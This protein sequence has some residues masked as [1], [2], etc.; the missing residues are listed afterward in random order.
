MPSRSSWPSPS[1]EITHPEDVE[2]DRE[3]VAALLDGRDR[4]LRGRAGLLRRPRAADLD[5][6]RAL[7]GARLRRPPGALH[8]PR[9]GHLGAQAHGGLGPAP[10]RPR[11][12]DRSVEPPALRGGA[13]PPGR[14]LPALRREGRAAA[15]GPRRLQGRQRQLRPQGG[16]RPA[17][18]RGRRA[19]AARAR[20]RRRGATGRRRVRGPAGQRLTRP[21]GRGGRAAARARR[22]R[23]PG[24]RGPSRV[25][26]RERGRRVPRRADRR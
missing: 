8:R 2:A 20:H 6:G 18:A 13:A 25:R 22:R 3:Q 11:S 7:A 23:D 15:H 16:R 26:D 17:Q 9:R 10:R 14:A 5:Q 21:G 4:A 24:P 1:Q 19:A 12:A